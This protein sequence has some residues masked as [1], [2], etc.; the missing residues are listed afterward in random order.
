M[1]WTHLPLHLQEE[2]ETLNWD[3]GCLSQDTLQRG[4][5]SIPMFPSPSLCSYLPCFQDSGSTRI[6]LQEEDSHLLSLGNWFAVK[7]TWPVTWCS[8]FTTRHFLFRPI[9]LLK[10]LREFCLF[11]FVNWLITSFLRLLFCFISLSQCFE[12]SNSIFW[13]IFSNYTCMW[14]KDSDGSIHTG[15]QWKI[16]PL[17]L[18]SLSCSLWQPLWILLTWFFWHYLH[19]AIKIYLYW[20]FMIC[21]GLGINCWQPT[22]E[23]KDKG[24]FHTPISL[25]SR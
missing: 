6:K 7:L 21:L 23:E 17:T 22:L 15:F 18:E 19:N 10:N 5:C 2:P 11:F 3:S 1:L 9:V 16:S 25:I 24:L 20:A 14:F 12:F 8:L 13:V 4:D